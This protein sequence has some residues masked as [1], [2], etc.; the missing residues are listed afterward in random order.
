MSEKPLMPVVWAINEGRSRHYPAMFRWILVALANRLRPSA[1]GRWEAWPSL[2]CLTDDTGA[3]RRCVQL[4]LRQYRDDGLLAITPG[5]GRGHTTVYR[6]LARLEKGASG[7]SFNGKRVQKRVHQVHPLP[8]VKG[9]KSSSKRVQNPT[10]ESTKKNPPSTS[11]LRSEVH[12]RANGRSHSLTEPE[13]FAEFYERYPRK[14]A[15]RPAAKAYG[16]ALNRGATQ[17]EILTGLER[18]QF[19]SDPQY[20]PHPATWLNAERWRDQPDLPT[21]SAADNREQRWNLGTLLA[22]NIEPEA[23]DDHRIPS[24]QRHP[25]AE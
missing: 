25:L 13:G 19:S 23:P 14:V 7:S 10:T 5:D 18:H 16:Q 3:S 20:R 17:A 6:L 24:A 8:A 9:A 22:P 15:R 11:S 21:R 2:D 12:T 1:E 4:A